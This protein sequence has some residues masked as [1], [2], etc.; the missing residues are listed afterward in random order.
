MYILI[1]VYRNR[2]RG[3]GRPDS[4]SPNSSCPCVLHACSF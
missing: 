1:S 4:F 2:K 3:G